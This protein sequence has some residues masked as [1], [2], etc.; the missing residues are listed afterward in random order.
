MQSGLDRKKGD[1]I[2]C[3]FLHYLSSQLNTGFDLMG[4]VD[5]LLIS[6]GEFYFIFLCVSHFFNEGLK[7]RKEKWEFMQH[8]DG[9]KM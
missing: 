2:L 3:A 1:D 4:L 9:V 5:M 7:I 6:A 8:G